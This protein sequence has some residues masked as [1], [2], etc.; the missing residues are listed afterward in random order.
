VADAKE[1]NQSSL[2]RV[3]STAP[4]RMRDF[5]QMP[6]LAKEDALIERVAWGV[7]LSLLFTAIWL[8]GALL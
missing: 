6:H 4:E 5:H 7:V 8:A 2:Y 3:E 1:C